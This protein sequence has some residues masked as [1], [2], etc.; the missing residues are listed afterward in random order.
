[1]GQHSAVVT[2]KPVSCMLALTQ[3]SYQRPNATKRGVCCHRSWKSW[4]LRAA[5]AFE[6]VYASNLSVDMKNSQP[7]ESATRKWA[8]GT[9]KE[10]LSHST[11][12]PQSSEWKRPFFPHID[13]PCTLTHLDNACFWRCRLRNSDLLLSNKACISLWYCRFRRKRRIRKHVAQDD[14]STDGKDG[15]FERNQRKHM[16]NA[17]TQTPALTFVFVRQYL[18]SVVAHS[19]PSESTCWAQT[20]ALCNAGPLPLVAC[21]WSG[22][23]DAASK[24]PIPLCRAG[25]ASASVRDDKNRAEGCFDTFLRI[26]YS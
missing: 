24:L 16:D 5:A 13:S 19:A 6:R 11:C 20:W 1:M 7:G 4:N 3:C 17:E 22:A 15:D 9:R 23:W 2:N 8:E 14:A 26:H 25:A 10:T 21:T 18:C 12:S